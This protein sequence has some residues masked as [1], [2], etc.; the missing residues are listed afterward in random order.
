VITGDKI[1][2]VFAEVPGVEKSDIKLNATENSLS[3]AVDTETRKYHKEVE[4]P[5]RVD[6]DSVKATYRNGVLEVTLKKLEKKKPSIK[7]IDIE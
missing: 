7:W 4:L 1:I 5:E 2:Q 6:P 3:I